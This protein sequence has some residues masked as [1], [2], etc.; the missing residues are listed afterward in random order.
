MENIDQSIYE[1]ADEGEKLGVEKGRKDGIEEGERRG[2][3]STIK[4]LVKNGLP[5]SEIAQRLSLSNEELNAML[6]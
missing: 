4:M 2:M 5:I 1:R 3:I 6:E